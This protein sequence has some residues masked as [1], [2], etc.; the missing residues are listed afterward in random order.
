MAD[1]PVSV[2]S[3]DLISPPLAAQDS[4]SNN[5]FLETYLT[6]LHSSS[7]S[8]FSDLRVYWSHD[9]PQLIQDK[10]KCAFQ[11]L[12]LDFFYRGL[13]QFWASVS[14]CGRR[15][16]TTSDQPF[17]LS[18]RYND[19]GKYRLCC[20][21]YTYCVDAMNN[22]GVVEDDVRMISDGAAVKAFLNGTPELLPDLKEWTP[23]VSSAIEC[24]LASCVMLPV[25]DPAQSC[26]VGVVEACS[27]S[28]TDFLEV[29]NKL[30]TALEVRI[31]FIEFRLG[32]FYG[33]RMVRCIMIKRL[34][35]IVE[36]AKGTGYGPGLLLN[37]LCK[38]C[39]KACRLRPVGKEGL[40]TFHAQEHLPYKRLD[41]C[42][43][44]MPMKQTIPALEHAKNEINDALKII[45]HMHGLVFADVWIAYKDGNQVSLPFLE[46][47]QANRVIRLKLTDYYSVILDDEDS[48]LGF[49][50]RNYCNACY[51]LP[52]KMGEGLIGKTFQNYKPYFIEDILELC[53]SESVLKLLSGF[54]SC[55]CFVIYLWST[56]TSDL[57]YVFEFFWKSSRDNVIM[58]ESLLLTFKR[59]LPS[60][61]IKSGLEL[62]DEIDILDVGNS[63][64][65][66][67]RYIKIFHRNKVSLKRG[68]QSKVEECLTPSKARGK[69]TPIELSREQIESQFGQTQ[70]KAAKKLNGDDNLLLSKYT[71]HVS[72]LKRKCKKEGIKLWQGKDHVEENQSDTYEEED[73][74]GAI[75]DNTREAS[76]DKNMVTIKAEYAGDVIMFSHPISSATSKA[77]EKEIV[78]RYEL[79]PDTRY[80]LQYLDVEN[81]EW[82]LF[83][84]DE[85]VTLFQKDKRNVRLLT[86]GKR[87]LVQLPHMNITRIENLTGKKKMIKSLIRFKHLLIKRS[88]RFIMT[89]RE[90]FAI[91]SDTKPPVLFREISD[92]LSIKE[93]EYNDIQ[94][95][96]SALSEE[97]E[98]LLGHIKKVETMLLKR[99]QTDQTIFLNKPKEFKAY[100]V[101]EGLGFENPHY[102]KRAI[103]F[104]PTLYDT[105]YFNLD[106][107]YRM[108]FTRS[109]EEVE[110]EHDKR[111]KQKDNVQIPFNYARLNDSYSKRE[112]SLSDD[113]IR[114]YS[115]EEFK[116][117]KSDDSPVDNSKFYE[118]RYYKTLKDLEDERRMNSSEKD[119]ML[120]KISDLQKQVFKLKGELQKFSNSS[121]SVH[122][123]SN[124]SDTSFVSASTNSADSVKS[125][126]ALQ[127]STIVNS[128]C[129]VCSAKKFVESEAVSRVK[130]LE[131]RNAQLSS[132]ISDFEQLIILE[133]RNFEKERKFFEEEKKVFEN[134]RKSF[135]LNSVK[136][137]KKI[138]DLENQIVFERKDFEKMKNVF[139]SKKN[140]LKKPSLRVGKYQNMMHDFEEEIHVVK[141]ERKCDEKKSVE[142]QKQIV[143]LQNQLSDIIAEPKKPS[144]VQKDFE[145]Q[146]K[147][148]KNEIKKLTSKLAGLS[149]D[150]MTEQ[151]LRLVQQKKLDDLLVERNML[152]TKVKGLVEIISKAHG[153]IHTN[154]STHGHIKSSGQIRPTNLFYDSR[155]DHSGIHLCSKCKFVWQV[156]GSNANVDHTKSFAS[157]SN[158][159]KNKSFQDTSFGAWLLNTSV[160]DPSINVVYERY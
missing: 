129:C 104:V 64:G 91:G 43:H 115:E 16:L 74:R 3:D 128:I 148:F 73:N 97:K 90:A 42:E 50:C 100:N 12:Q 95:K 87:L 135:E 9:D 57:D 15:L 116:Q 123:S 113:Y 22:V 114:S 147:A 36:M 152:S 144:L 111:R 84:C 54:C 45:W 51:R 59:Y 139:E 41:M 61:K 31:S 146:K 109:S 21:N 78:K 28:S 34:Y 62:G 7:P 132:Q 83:T 145:D 52:L 138:S 127:L 151:R 156:K 19:H 25:F 107:K 142:L 143:I 89:T 141:S 153:S 119:Q 121:S 88:V 117:F 105:I 85:N 137:S 75:R 94:T 160:Q 6:T 106:K 14:V 80:K 53:D 136:L 158:V 150:I 122:K 140:S 154:V 40:K 155:A 103:R 68:R 55:S 48:G 124:T 26:C 134:E 65:S 67:N 71:F 11:D 79:D 66:E 149:T 108:R 72:T 102:L 27:S 76:L 159:L 24:G 81:N 101:R 99:G 1:S 125:E 37:R 131:L 23:L 118:F 77:M 120:C 133:R 63:K 8:F 4:S 157:K 86:Y 5:T 30:N 33:Y 13:I 82:I 49:V 96:F 39:S 60:F 2:S 35:D 69:T 110:A 32:F 20:L 38:A 70:E 17:I 46:D 126:N 18:T 112:I 44:F 92:K 93:K 47:G 98:V 56:K 58:L 130:S 29:F 10:I